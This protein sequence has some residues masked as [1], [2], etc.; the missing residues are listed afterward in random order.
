MQAEGEIADR[1]DRVRILPSVVQ[2]T[3]YPRAR[4]GFYKSDGLIDGGLGYASVD[5]DLY[6]LEDGSVGSR[7]VISLVA[8]NQVS[9]WN[10]DV[11]EQ[12]CSGKRCSL[13][14]ARPIIDNSQSGS[15]ALCD[16]VPGTTFS[17]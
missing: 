2:A 1:L 12:H 5:C 17:V 16:R 7:L 4:F 15:V 3:V 14:E 13:A 9:L 11:V 8:R 10:L 6:D